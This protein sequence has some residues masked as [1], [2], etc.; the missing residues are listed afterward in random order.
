M[1]TGRIIADVLT[2]FVPR[3]IEWLFASIVFCLGFK[4]LRPED[5]F[6]SAPA[7]YRILSSL[8]PEPVWGWILFI[9]GGARLVALK[10][11]I[12]VVGNETR[13]LIGSEMS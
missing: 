10:S 7:T 1:I 4:L 5:T 13:G 9:V 11:A 6:A 8:A 12:S 2:H 3:R